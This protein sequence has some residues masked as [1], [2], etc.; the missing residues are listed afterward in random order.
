MV[1]IRDE[2]RIA[3]LKKIGRILNITGIDCLGAGML[4]AVVSLFSGP[5]NSP[6]P[7]EDL[8]LYQFLA[9]FLGWTFSQIGLYLAHRYIRDPRPDEVIDMSVR[10]V[11]KNGRLY[12][13]VLPAPRVLH[14]PSGLF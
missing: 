7:I 12:H 14:I 10:K 1:V 8:F 9:L 3:R 4:V 5:E 2:A 13:Y 6:V 11:A